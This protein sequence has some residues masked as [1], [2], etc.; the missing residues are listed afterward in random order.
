MQWILR[1]AS[2]SSATI[3]HIILTIGYVR[4]WTS[5]EIQ[6]R[7]FPDDDQRPDRLVAALTSFTNLR[8]LT[9]YRALLLPPSPSFCGRP[10]LTL[11]NRLIYFVRKFRSTLETLE[12]LGVDFALDSL[13]DRQ[14]RI[15]RSFKKFARAVA[16]ESSDAPLKSVVLVSDNNVD[17]QVMQLVSEDIVALFRQGG[18]ELTLLV[19]GP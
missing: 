11:P 7:S 6:P 15:G 8:I 1:A 17:E 19:A 3:Q 2:A 13:L 5:A 10:P 16:S 14:K 9:V 12:L 4:H 18:V